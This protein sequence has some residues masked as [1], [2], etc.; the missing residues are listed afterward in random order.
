MTCSSPPSHFQIILSL[1]LY[2]YY[3]NPN[4]V[5]LVYSFMI[6]TFFMYVFLSKAFNFAHV[7]SHICIVFYCFLFIIFAFFI[8]FFSFLVFIIIVSFCHFI[9]YQLRFHTDIILIVIIGVQCFARPQVFNI[10][11]DFN[12]DFVRM[13]MISS[14]VTRQPD[15]S[16]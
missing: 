5:M 10:F 15:C 7:L 14:S 2:A 6:L 8:S 11:T 16:D 4:P 13:A 12:N 3:R 9:F 1:S